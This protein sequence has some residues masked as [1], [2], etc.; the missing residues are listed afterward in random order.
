MDNITHS[1]VGLAVGEAAYRLC[2]RKQPASASLPRAPFWWVSAI[3]NNLPDLD[4]LYAP[5]TPGKI[6]YLLHHRGHTH[7]LGM[8]LP[9]FLLVLAFAYLVFRF[10][11][12]RPTRREWKTLGILCLLGPLIHISLDA[13]NSYGV[14]P[15]WPFSSKWLYGDTLFIIEPL[16]WFMFIPL[17]V[18]QPISKAWRGVLSLFIPFAFVLAFSSGLVSMVTFAF[19]MLWLILFFILSLKLSARAMLSTT[20]VAFVLVLLAFNITSGIARQQITDAEN[21]GEY[22]IVDIALSPLP[23]NPFCWTAVLIQKNSSQHRFKMRN[24]IHTISPAI[25]PLG[26][27]TELLPATLAHEKNQ[28]SSTV[29]WADFE[30]TTDEFTRLNTENCMANAFFRF[31]RA[32]YYEP[33]I[34]TLL[35]KD[36]RFQSRGPSFAQIEAQLEYPEGSCPRF[37]PSW[38]PPRSDLLEISN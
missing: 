9:Q 20:G 30:G 33:L 34:S 14:H 16:L 10:T 36:M 11:K 19:L 12:Q 23:A 17:L 13:L 24:G 21:G 31:A 8:V 22:S 37:L 25:F 6:G 29:W 1:L 28:T 3:A 27:C 7:T 35:L 26:Q 32:P 2:R 15:G 5:I 4:S 38:D 18:S